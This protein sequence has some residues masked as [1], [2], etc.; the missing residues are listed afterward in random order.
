MANII[1]TNLVDGE[2]ATNYATF[3]H[4]TNTTENHGVLNFDMPVLNTSTG[5]YEVRNIEGF[6]VQN[7]QIDNSTLEDD[8]EEMSSSDRLNPTKVF[9]WIAKKAKRLLCPTCM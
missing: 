8:E 9:W 5:F 7:T 6:D 1:C 3:K 2:L 4:E